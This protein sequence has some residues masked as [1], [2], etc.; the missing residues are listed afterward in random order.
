MRILLLIITFC[1]F[2]FVQTTQAQVA[3]EA[4]QQAPK[5]GAEQ[6]EV[7][8]QK[9][10]TNL[11]LSAQQVKELR[12]VNVDFAEKMKTVVSKD[13]TAMR[14]QIMTLKAEKRKAYKAYLTP[15][16]YKVWLEKEKG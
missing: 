12:A 9:M 14:K 13:K 15:A 11:S 1:T 7:D 10:K 2:S 5:S 16:Q 6:L 4:Q 3:T 8:L